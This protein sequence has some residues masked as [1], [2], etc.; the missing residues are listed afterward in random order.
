[1]QSGF[2]HFAH[3]RRVVRSVN[4]Q[5]H[6]KAVRDIWNRVRYVG[7]APLSDSAVFAPARSVTFG[8][9]AGPRGIKFR[10]RHS[11]LVLGGDWDT[12]RKPLDL[13]ADLRMKS[14]RMRF[15][16]GADWQET[17]I[18]QRFAAEIAQGKTPDE[19][20]TLDD[21]Q[22]RYA[23]LDRVFHETRARG[24]MLRPSETPEAFRRDHGGVLLHVARDGT[25]LKSG[26]GG[27]RFAIAWILDLPKMPAQ[28]G[29]VHRAALENGSLAPLLQAD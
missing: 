23:L 12:Q 25:C 19:C 13:D 10:R 16:Q 5:V 4:Q 3:P 17:P 26:G 21:L 6:V 2:L 14:C 7:R 15:E 20:R 11:G 24:R 8:Y 9:S 28:V 29:V 18:Y 1:M 22:A 27:H